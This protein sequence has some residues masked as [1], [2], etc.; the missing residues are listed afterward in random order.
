VRDPDVRVSQAERD[1]VVNVLATH[2]ADGR[3]SLGEYEERVVDALAATT[4]RDLDALFTDLPGGTPAPA[5]AAAAPAGATAPVPSPGRVARPE[6][7]RGP[8]PK[9]PL[10]LVVV[11]LGVF[12]TPWA[13][14]LLFPVLGGGS[15]GHHHRHG[16]GRARWDRDGWDGWSRDDRESVRTL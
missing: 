3:L 14:F 1:A 11:A 15:G 9:V 10:V 2:Y 6:R 5:P 16:H 4:G 8:T 13:F 7:G 12:V